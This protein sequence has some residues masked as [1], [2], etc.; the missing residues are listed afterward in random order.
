MP[1]FDFRVQCIGLPA[2]E[3]TPAL[4]RCLTD[5]PVKSR[6]RSINRLCGGI[7]DLPK[8]PPSGGINEGE[9]RLA[10]AYQG[11]ASIRTQQGRVLPAE[12]GK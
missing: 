9:D 5:T 8:F 1:V 4:L 3:F 12:S 7:I 6:K 10:E 2:A 11:L